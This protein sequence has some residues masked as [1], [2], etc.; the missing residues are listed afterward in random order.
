MPTLEMGAVTKIEHGTR[1]MFCVPYLQ[2]KSDSRHKVSAE[3]KLAAWLSLQMD[4]TKFDFGAGRTKR[5]MTWSKPD[6]A[7][8]QSVANTAPNS[9]L[10]PQLESASGSFKRNAFLES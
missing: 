1:Q 6:T 3:S 4:Q 8:K 10:S 5:L 2:Q 7:L 9:H